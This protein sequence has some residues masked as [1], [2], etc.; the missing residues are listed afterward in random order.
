MAVTECKF[1]DLEVAS[2]DSTSILIYIYQSW[3]KWTNLTHVIADHN[4]HST[5]PKGHFGRDENSSKW[6]VDFLWNFRIATTS[7]QRDEL[8]STAAHCDKSA[9]TLDIYN[10]LTVERSFIS[11]NV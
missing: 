9:H 6:Q 3:F 2:S 8:L 7:L 10:D 11:L 1:A 5:R 4:S